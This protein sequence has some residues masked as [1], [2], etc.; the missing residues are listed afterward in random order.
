MNNLTNDLPPFGDL[1]ESE[2]SIKM[3]IPSPLATAIAE[4]VEGQFALQYFG[5][6]FNTL[7]LASIIQRHLTPLIEKGERQEK[8]L[9]VA[10][11]RLHMICGSYM[12]IAYGEPEAYFYE[13]IDTMGPDMDMVSKA[14]KS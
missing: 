4:D 8:A 3:T 9:K 13:T 12:S 1:E 5:K 14:L 6:E 7:S 2:Y 11:D 10:Y